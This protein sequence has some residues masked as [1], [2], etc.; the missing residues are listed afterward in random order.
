MGFKKWT[1]K[2][3]RFCRE[4]LKSF[5]FNVSIGTIRKGLKKLGISLKK[6]KKYLNNR[7]HPDRNTQFLKI[8]KY[9]QEYTKM[10]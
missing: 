3:L 2:T 9:I 7:N 8:N 1:K 5:G 6:N 4:E 10:G